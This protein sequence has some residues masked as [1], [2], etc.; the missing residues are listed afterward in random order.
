M[1]VPELRAELDV[2]V[3]RLAR[4]ERVLNGEEVPV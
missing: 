3:E 4:V 1:T 2:I